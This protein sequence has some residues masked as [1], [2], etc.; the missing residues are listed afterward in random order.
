MRRRLREIGN[1]LLHHTLS[2]MAAELNA[3]KDRF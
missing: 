3:V 1:E 2:F